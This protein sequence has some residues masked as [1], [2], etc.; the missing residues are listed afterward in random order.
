VE[1]RNADIPVYCMFVAPVI[2]RDTL[3]MYW[4]SLI[5]GYEGAKQNIIPFTIDQYCSVLRKC[6]QAYQANG[7]RVAHHHLRA[8]FDSVIGEARG[9]DNSQTWIGKMD[10][11]IEGWQ[12]A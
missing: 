10:S 8:L 11:L 3:N 9:T 12:I 7:V 1:K 6:V 4:F 2:H 5:A